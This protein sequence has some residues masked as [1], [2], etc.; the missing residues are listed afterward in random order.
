MED[1]AAVYAV[2]VLLIYPWTLTRFFW[3]LS[4]W[5][6][7][8]PFGDLGNIF[9]YMMAVN[10]LESILVLLAPLG[11]S[12]LLPRG[13]FYERFVSR[14]VS[15]VLLGL[16][17]LIFLNRNMDAT[18]LFPWAMVRLIPLVLLVI[19]ILVFLLDRISIV[20]SFLNELANRALIFLYITIPI[21]LISV[22]IVV[23]R[24]MT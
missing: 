3:K 2:I 16:G 5:L 8:T 13:W 9:A 20:R 4:S 23:I 15:L 12:I 17:Y 21:S 14:G 22:L 1:I 7:F 19:P 11:L 24:N 6:L 10:F 18:A